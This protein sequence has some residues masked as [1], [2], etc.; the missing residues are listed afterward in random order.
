M[1]NFSI[2]MGKYINMLKV[3]KNYVIVAVIVVV[4]LAVLAYLYSKYEGFSPED[5]TL[6]K[7]THDAVVK[8][9]EEIPQDAETGREQINNGVNY[10]DM[11]SREIVLADAKATGCEEATV[12][13]N[14]EINEAVVDATVGVVGEAVQGPDFM[15]LAEKKSAD[16]GIQYA[17]TDML[18]DN[19]AEA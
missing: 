19:Y 8:T 4:V 6:V 1:E 13:V 14:T 2:M 5:C 11:Q 9:M 3:N 12:P 17:G 15:D 18:N 16:D 7:S 10:H